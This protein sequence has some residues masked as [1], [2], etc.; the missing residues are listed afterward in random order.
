MLTK[1]EF[2]GPKPVSLITNIHLSGVNTG[3]Y[4]KKEKLSK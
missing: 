1:S 4:N 2:S 3:K